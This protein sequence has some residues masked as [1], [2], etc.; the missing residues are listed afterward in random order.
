MACLL[1]EEVEQ[2]QPQAALQVR[3]QLGTE[4][5]FDLSERGGYALSL[6]LEELPDQEMLLRLAAQSN[7]LQV[8][9]VGLAVCEA[10]GNS[11]PITEPPSHS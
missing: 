3:D 8:L 7:P 9:K 2:S 5:R 6:I 1:S 11:A 10:L 4:V